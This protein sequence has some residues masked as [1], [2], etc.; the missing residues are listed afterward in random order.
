MLHLQ[1]KNKKQIGK[2][3]TEYQILYDPIKRHIL[4]LRYEH[5]CTYLF[6]QV[7]N[8]KGTRLFPVVACAAW[9]WGRRQG[10]EGLGVCVGGVLWADTFI[11][12]LFVYLFL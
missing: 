9:Q 10:W 12:S 6:R 8:A 1:L 3:N 7:R 4:V 2:Q 11:F 5:P